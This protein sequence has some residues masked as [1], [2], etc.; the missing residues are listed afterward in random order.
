M[1][2]NKE[3]LRINRVEAI[4]AFIENNLDDDLSLE[5][6]S[7]M[8]AMSPYHFHR[9]FSKHVGKSLGAYVRGLRLEK[10]ANLLKDGC[11]EIKEV[12]YEAKYSEVAS[13]HRAF[14]SKFG[15]APG[16]YREKFGWSQSSIETINR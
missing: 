15:C 5:K 10:A 3:Q 1:L 4:K 16:V 13:F 14:T 11:A 6:V 7:N 8:A 12:A 9:N 2:N